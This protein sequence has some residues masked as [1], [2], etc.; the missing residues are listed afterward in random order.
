[1]H[2][3]D[4]AV[5]T[6]VPGLQRLK[7]YKA[8]VELD[9]GIISIKRTRNNTHVACTDRKGNTKVYMSGGWLGFRGS[10]EGSTFVGELVI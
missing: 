3:E 5:S 9:R 6:A 8:D 2:D 1:M 7:Q 4:S 10:K